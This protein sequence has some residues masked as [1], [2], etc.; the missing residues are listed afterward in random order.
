MNTLLKTG[1]VGLGI[2]AVCLGGFGVGMVVAGDDTWNRPMSP[3]APRPSVTHSAAGTR[4][5]P[6]NDLRC[7]VVVDVT[8]FTYPCWRSPRPGRLRSVRFVGHGLPGYAGRRVARPSPGSESV[9]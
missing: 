5:R 6:L 2:C 7:D 8:P 4:R 3:H 9:C 1:A